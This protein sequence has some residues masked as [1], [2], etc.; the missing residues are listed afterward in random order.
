MGGELK[1]EYDLLTRQN[2]SSKDRRWLDLYVKACPYR[3]GLEKLGYLKTKE[4]RLAIE[5]LEKTFPNKCKGE[6][7]L[8]RLGSGYRV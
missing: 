5:D 3:D 2:V 6:K 1:K 7:Y 4:I 8:E